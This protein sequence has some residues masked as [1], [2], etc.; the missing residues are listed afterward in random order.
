MPGR[1]SLTAQYPGRAAIFC[2]WS[3][4]LSE[5]AR[6]EAHQR[7]NVTSSPGSKGS[8]HKPAL[9]RQRSPDFKL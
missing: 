3:Y 7:S 5:L 9:A 1:G 2:G 6:P 8:V 4:D